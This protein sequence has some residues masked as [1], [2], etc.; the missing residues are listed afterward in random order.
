MKV[1][2]HGRIIAIFSESG[3]TREN[4]AWHRTNVQI[5]SQVPGKGF[6]LE[7]LPVFGRDGQPAVIDPILVEANGKQRDVA[8]YA[9]VQARKDRPGE[10][11]VRPISVDWHGTEKRIGTP[12]EAPAA[13]GK[14]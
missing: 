4:K 8:I 7:T 13:G 11:D 6:E 9:D 5:M 1:T 10:L 12:A 14:S 3:T 2:L